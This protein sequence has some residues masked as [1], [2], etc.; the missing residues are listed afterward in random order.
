[1]WVNFNWETELDLE[2]ALDQQEEITELIEESRFVVKTAVL[3][4]ELDDWPG[5][6]QRQAQ[7]RHAGTM[8]LSR[9][10]L[11]LSRVSPP[12]PAL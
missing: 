1:M 6:L 2:A 4:E 12:P 8:W 7:V 11:A 9:S 10:G 5:S 3:E